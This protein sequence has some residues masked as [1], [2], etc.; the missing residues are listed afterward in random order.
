[1]HDKFSKLSWIS[2]GAE[3]NHWGKL[4]FNSEHEAHVGGDD[5]A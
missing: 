5:L 1:M 2:M 4:D 3:S